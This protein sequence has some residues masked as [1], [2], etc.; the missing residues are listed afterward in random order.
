MK[1]SL[2][3]D[4]NNCQGS[5]SESKSSSIY[6]ESDCEWELRWQIWN[7]ESDAIEYHIKD[8][9]RWH[10]DCINAKI[11]VDK[12]LPQI[13][14]SLAQSCTVYSRWKISKQSSPQN[15]IS[16]WTH[17]DSFRCVKGIWGVLQIGLQSKGARPLRRGLSSLKRVR[18]MWA[19]LM[20]LLSDCLLHRGF[21]QK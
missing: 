10:L 5:I 6:F 3:V 20:C 11:L 2:M 1:R 21:V 19:V 14:C 7:C 15:F 13:D 12:T 16:N 4:V 9:G 17:P 8:Q 18:V